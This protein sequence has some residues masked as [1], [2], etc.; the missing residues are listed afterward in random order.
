MMRKLITVLL[1]LFGLGLFTL[2]AVAQSV[3]PFDFPQARLNG[4]TL[5]EGTRYVLILPYNN[6]DA[7]YDLSVTVDLPL[8]SQLISAQQSEGV[9]FV[10][11]SANESAYQLFWDAPEI[12]SGN[13]FAPFTFTLTQP[14]TTF[15]PVKMT[16]RDSLNEAQSAEIVL[17]PNTLNAVGQGASFNPEAPIPAEQF[18]FIGDTGVV[19]YT[20]QEMPAS[21]ISVREMAVEENPPAEMGDF[22]WCSGLELQGAGG[23]TV[24][25]PLRKPLPP[26]MP[27]TLFAQEGGVWRIL[28]IQGYVSADG[29]YA[30]YDHPG[31]IIF[32]GTEAENQ[33]AEAPPAPPPPPDT[34]GDGRTDDVDSCPNQGDAGF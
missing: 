33:P 34:D 25:V 29:L 9:N 28:D 32:T 11:A 1:L 24:Y 19:I 5:P 22:W 31:G 16:W 15:I 4:L 27:L 23:V 30:V 2:S 10:G 3:A 14:I 6:S 21:A 18:T 26:L 17:L 7:L 12:L 20:S 8:G 13:L